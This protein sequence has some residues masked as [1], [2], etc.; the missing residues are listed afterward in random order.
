[1]NKVQALT[2][3]N[4]Q[5]LA[6]EIGL[7]ENYDLSYLYPLYEDVCTFLDQISDT[8]IMDKV[9]SINPFVLFL[10]TINEHLY[11]I[12][13]FGKEQKD[14]IE[15]DNEYRNRIISVI[16]DK[17]LT[18]EK[19]SYKF[20]RIGNKYLP[21][22]STISLYTNFI[23]GML[24]RFKQNAPEETLIVDLLQKGFSMVRCIIELL[25]GG[26]ET[27]AFS[28]W[29]TL[30]ETECIAILIYNYK[31]PIIDSYI[32]HMKYG[33]TYRERDENLPQND[34]IFAKIK[35]EMAVLD[36]KSKD[37]KKYIEYGWLLSIPG[38]KIDDNMK[39]NFRDGVEKLANLSSYSSWYQTSSEIA[40]S[41]PLLIYSRKEYF[42]LASLLNTYESFIRLEAIFYNVYSSVVSE[43][44]TKRYLLMRNLYLA[45]MIAIHKKE[46]ERFK[47]INTKK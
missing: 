34:A 42:Y 46:Q 16:A 9:T 47:S 37:M 43:E 26:F 14:K 44:E 4:C 36:L 3:E 45:Q 35:S 22:I 8:N 39:L 20:S 28:T 11:T 13:G 5:L 18:N 12:E 31:K 2:L 10:Y 41:S 38:T 19:L 27:E 40:H 33:I 7:S 17:Y 1:M 6:K 23:L 30:H 21:T 25:N 32:K 15:K 24:M 29:R